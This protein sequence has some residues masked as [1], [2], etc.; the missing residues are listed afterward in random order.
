MAKEIYITR[1]GKAVDKKPVEDFSDAALF[2]LSQLGF[3]GD[4]KQT[5]IL[6]S[7]ANRGILNCS[8][9]WGK[10]TVMAIK[11]IHRAYTRP[12]SLIVVAGPTDRQSA[13][14]LQ[15]AEEFVPILG[16][17]PRGDGANEVSL[18]FPNGSRIIGLPGSPATVRG[19]SKV[20]MLV[21]D[22]AA[23]MDM[24]MYTALSPM[25]AV[26]GGDLWVMSTPCGRQGFFY[27]IWAHGGAR[28]ERVMAK[29]TECPGRIPSDFLEQQR[30]ELGPASFEQEF[31]CEFVD[32]GG[33][34]FAQDMLERALDAYVA[35][36]IFASNFEKDGKK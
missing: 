25:L 36:L 11:A 13:E 33:Q 22:E 7:Q 5:A 32:A 21:I 16:I 15:K 26:G 29:A 19:F 23:Y 1:E 28:W 12:K 9:Q 3:E 20:S 4:E 34:V 6:R 30:S 8:R 18:K 17:E 35:P 10:S 31:M 27:Q 24:A 14:F 2:A